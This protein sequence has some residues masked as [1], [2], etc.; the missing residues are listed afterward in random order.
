MSHELQIV[1][2]AQAPGAAAQH[3]NPFPC[4]RSAGRRIH[5]TCIVCRHPLQSPDIDRIVHHIPAA[6]GLAGMLTDKPACGRE[7]VVLADQPHRVRI[8]PLPDQGYVSRHIHMSRTEGHAGHRLVVAAG[9]S[10]VPDMFNIVIP[11]AHQSLVDHAGRLVADGAVRR[12]HNGEGCLLHVVQ[13]LH[14]GLSVQHVLDKMVQLSKSD[15]AGHAFPAG[16]GV[17]QLQEGSGHV[18]GTQ[19]RRAGLDPSLQILVETFHDNPGS[20]G[21]LNL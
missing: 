18:H 9:T 2:S 3:G 8:A 10:A 1:G 14:G 6:S 15:P 21:S 5:L 12:L 19:S 11:V 17:A 4:R 16:L 13:C 7:R 20:V